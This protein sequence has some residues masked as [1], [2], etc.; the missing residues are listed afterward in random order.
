ME[1]VAR[2]P[3]APAKPR[4]RRLAA[5][6]LAVLAVVTG[7]MIALAA[8]DVGGVRTR[9][10][11][12]AA[13]PTRAV[14]LAVLPIVNLTGDPDQDY[15]SDGLTEEMIAQLGSLHPQGLSV[16]ARGS[17]MRYKNSNTPIDQ[18]GRDLQVEYVLEGSARREGGA[19]ASPPNSSRCGTR[20]S[21]GRTRMSVRC[22][23]SWPCK[24]RWPGRW[25]GRWR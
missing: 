7:L 12:G 24:A 10:R 16:I 14:R 8:F 18:V 21:S 5:S 15:L 19:F 3:E 11:G 25:P 9:L 6:A 20:R 1:M 23:A 4:R 22:P 2:P 13:S 17:V